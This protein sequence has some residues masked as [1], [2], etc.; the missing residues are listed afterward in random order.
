MGELLNLIKF[1]LKVPVCATRL[2]LNVDLM[3]LNNRNEKKE[4]KRKG[5]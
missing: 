3:T 1:T 2:V 5:M 4:K